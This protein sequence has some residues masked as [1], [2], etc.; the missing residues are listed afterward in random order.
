MFTFQFSWLNYN[1]THNAE[2]RVEVENMTVIYFFE[3]HVIR[4]FPVIDVFFC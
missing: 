2:G 1:I 4:L 3:R